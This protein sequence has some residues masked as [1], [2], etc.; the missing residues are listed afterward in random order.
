MGTCAD[1][2]W[3]QDITLTKMGV[4][5]FYNIGNNDVRYMVLVEDLG[6]KP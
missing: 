6:E 5:K 3:L 1:K 4:F 2:V